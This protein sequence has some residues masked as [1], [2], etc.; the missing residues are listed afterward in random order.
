MLEQIQIALFAA[1]DILDAMSDEDKNKLTAN[2]TFGESLEIIVAELEELELQVTGK[3][4][5]VKDEFAALMTGESN[6]SE[7]E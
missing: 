6:E 7:N 3:K 1:Y 5:C 2:E 4:R